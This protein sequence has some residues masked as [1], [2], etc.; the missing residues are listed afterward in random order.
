MRVELTETAPQ[1]AVEFGILEQPTA[2][3]GLWENQGQDER[4]STVAWVLWLK[5]GQTGSLLSP[6]WSP[7]T[8]WAL[9]LQLLAL[10]SL[11]CFREKPRHKILVPPPLGA[12]P[13]ICGGHV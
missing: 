9:A 6:A 7:G 13:Q 5:G 3:H 10:L 1:W 11:V 4:A 12:A 2:S 8:I